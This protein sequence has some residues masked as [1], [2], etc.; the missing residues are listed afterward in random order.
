MARFDSL[1]DGLLL[2][3]AARTDV[4]GI[5]GLCLTSHRMRSKLVNALRTRPDFAN[6]LDC[7]EIGGLTKETCEKLVA[8]KVE[9]E[10]SVS[11]PAWNA[12]YDLPRATYPG[13]ADLATVA[14]MKTL[15]GFI[16]AGIAVAIACAKSL[17]SLKLKVNAIDYTKLGFVLRSDDRG[18]R[19]TVPGITGYRSEVRFLL[20]SRLESMN[21][22]QDDGV[23]RHDGGC[24]C[25]C[26]IPTMYNQ[27][28][29]FIH[30]K[31]L[32]MPFACLEIETSEF[33]WL[34]ELVTSFQT[35]LDIELRFK[36]N[37]LSTAW[38]ICTHFVGERETI[39][40][41]RRWKQQ[42]NTRITTVFG[43]AKFNDCV[44]NIERKAPKSYDTGDL[45]RALE[46][47]LATT[48]ELLTKEMELMDA[49]GYE[50][51]SIFHDPTREVVDS[52]T[53][54]S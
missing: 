48:H 35:L 13:A 12:W 8:V 10:K 7:L 37:L 32:V 16:F 41:V 1:P 27:L 39:T 25:C 28:G 6:G 40:V 50:P 43:N 51:P 17:K 31:R 36:T 3:I 30:L 20:Q 34:D 54:S 47:C 29:S 4:T 19:W 24:D 11:G 2:D 52:A 5:L 15:S 53:S 46:R 22:M 21:I 42:S 45:D 23:L 26:T 18:D 33:K 14:S 9:F 38:T 44:A 49:L